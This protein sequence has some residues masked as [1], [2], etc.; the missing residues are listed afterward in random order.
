MVVWLARLLCILDITSSILG[1]DTGH[2][3]QRSR[4]T[5]ASFQILPI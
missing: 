3:T 1:E 5:A 4:P 2:L